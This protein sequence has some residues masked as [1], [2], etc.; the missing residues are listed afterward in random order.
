M[1][2]NNHIFI[3]TNDRG[4]GSKRKSCGRHGGIEIRQEL[5][6]LINSNN[7]KGQIRANKS[8]CLDVCE[9]GPVLVSYP[10]GKWY[11]NIQMKN[12]KNIFQELL[13]N[14]NSKNEIIS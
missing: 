1:K 8:G 9:N 14:D 3:C 6:K 5:V 4:D 10:K 7:L 13:L 12:V 2:Y 11:E